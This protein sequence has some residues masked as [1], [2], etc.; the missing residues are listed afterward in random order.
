MEELGLVLPVVFPPAG[1]YVG[2]VVGAGVVVVG[3]HGPVVG[4][5]VIVGKVGSDLTLEEGREAARM[6]ALSILATLDAELW[7]GGVKSRR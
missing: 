1:N 2:C 6:T 7:F 4:D 5:R 3:S